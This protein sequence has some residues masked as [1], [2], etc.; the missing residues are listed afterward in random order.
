MK[1]HSSS[2]F[3][4]TFKI[5]DLGLSHFRRILEG[6]EEAVDL[7]SKGTRT[8]GKLPA[9]AGLCAAADHAQE[10]LNATQRAAELSIAEIL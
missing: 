2:G 3:G 9:M 4:W 8:Y 6:Q 7:D 10:L 1:R 5:A